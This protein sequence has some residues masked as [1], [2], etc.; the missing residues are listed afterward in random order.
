MDIV[1][2]VLLILI[3]LILIYLFFLVNKKCKTNYELFSF[4]DVTEPIDLHN[5]GCF[6]PKMTKDEYNLYIE[7]IKIVSTI[8]EK[9]NIDWIPVSGNLLAIYRHNSIFIPWDDDF[10]MV[11]KK[12]DVDR[13]IKVLEEE[14]PNSNYNANM[15]NNSWYLGG[16]LYKIYFNK[17]KC[18]I[19]STYN[20]KKYTWPFI[21]L[22]VDVPK[23]SNWFSLHNLEEFEYPL[24]SKYI[25]GI[26]IKV[27]S[28]GTRSYE[29]FKKQG[30]FENCIKQN[31]SHKLEKQIDCK[32]PGEVLC[33]IISPKQ[34]N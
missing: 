8:L 32:G 28:K 5:R 15:W 9:H 14:L 23:N 29:S 7:L 31:T 6:E 26:H 4:Q 21:D 18:N 11:V 3:F 2:A 30:L 17:E 13:T 1:T 22:F 20:D 19:V 12:E 33:K 24:I 16:M 10:D 27:P 34:A 25:E